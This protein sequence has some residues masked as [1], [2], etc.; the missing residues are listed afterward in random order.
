MENH[1]KVMSKKIYIEA[2]DYYNKIFFN[3]IFDMS[4]KAFENIVKIFDKTN[5]KF[6]KDDY[7]SACRSFFNSIIYDD[8]H[9]DLRYFLGLQVKDYEKDTLDSIILVSHNEDFFLSH[10]IE[11]LPSSFGYKKAKDMK[12]II[13]I[14]RNLNKN[15]PK[16]IENK[17]K[18]IDKIQNEFLK[19]ADKIIKS[20]EDNKNI[21][22]IQKNINLVKTMFK[23]NATLLK[24]YTIY[25]AKTIR[26][27]MVDAK[28]L[29]PHLKFFKK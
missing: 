10:M 1:V 5:G 23:V 2:F 19:S 29:K 15:L 4:I 16:I 7:N 27:V 8:N 26:Q 12:E 17:S 24:N 20:A 21:S 6:S 11:D 25:T 14:A 18:D 13:K 9:G 3:K 22:E 28:T